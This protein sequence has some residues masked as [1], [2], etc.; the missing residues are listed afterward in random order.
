MGRCAALRGLTDGVGTPDPNAIILANWCSYYDYYFSQSCI[1][2]NRLSGALVGVWGSDFIGWRPGS[3]SWRASR[4][5]GTTG[6][7]SAPG[8]PP[9]PDGARGQGMGAAAPA[10]VI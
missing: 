3:A 1:F 10:P 2:L 6:T 9:S 7:R 8:T 5:P 4:A